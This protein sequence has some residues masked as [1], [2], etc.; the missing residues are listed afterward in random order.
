MSDIDS[1]NYDR[2]AAKRSGGN[3][4][5]RPR[6]APRDDRSKSLATTGRRCA[7]RTA[8]WRQGF[9]GAD[10]WSVEV[11]PLAVTPVAGA[12][13]AFAWLASSATAALAMSLRPAP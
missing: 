2:S 7:E 12:A 5:K 13:A 8:G 6:G 11:A 10:A 9:A 1:A 4:Q 3:P